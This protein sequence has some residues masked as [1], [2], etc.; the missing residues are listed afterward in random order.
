LSS[1]LNSLHLCFKLLSVHSAMPDAPQNA[2]E[3]VKC[4]DMR[5]KS[6][7]IVMYNFGVGPRFAYVSTAFASSMRTHIGVV[8]DELVGLKQSLFLC[9][10]GK[11]SRACHRQV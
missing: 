6:S 11:H 9:S 2:H 3:L 10:D 5:F 7:S 4:L 1:L 8:Y